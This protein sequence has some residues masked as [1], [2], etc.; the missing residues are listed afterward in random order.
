LRSAGDPNNPRQSIGISLVLVGVTLAIYAQSFSFG[1]VGF[2]D[3]EYLGGS[4][5]LQNELSIEGLK[6]A[7]T[8]PAMS[9]YT[10]LTL[11][12]HMFDRTLFGDNAGGYHL[13]NAVLHALN[14]VLLFFTL[15]SMTGARWRSATVAL[16][17]AVHPLN[18]ESVAWISERKNVLSTL[19]WI[20]TLWAYARYARRPGVAR[21][22]GVALLLALGLLAKPMLVTLPLALLLLDYWPLGRVRWR[23]STA[24]RQ[25]SPFAARSIGFL[26]AEKL[27]LLAISAAASVATYRA[28][29]RG[30]VATESLTLLERLANAAVA[31]AR[32]LGKLVWPSDLAMHYPHPYLP[33]MGGIPLEAWQ[34]AGSLLLLLALTVASIAALR[35]RYLAVGWL[36]FLG[37]L[38][39]TIG[40]VQVGHQALADRYAYVPAIGL[41]LALSWAGAE[42]IARLRAWRPALAHSLLAVAAAGIAALALT[43]WH[44]VGYWRDSIS[45]FERTLALIPKNPKVSF[46]LANEYRARGNVKEAIRH[47]RIA[48]ETDP[49]ALR[50]LVNLGGA[51][52]SAGEH[53]AAIET[54]KAVLNL[55]PLHAHAY[56]NLGVALQMKGESASALASFRRAIELDSRQADAHS[57][58]AKALSLQGKHEEAIAHYREALESP[59]L[60]DPAGTSLALGN[61]LFNLGR[62]EAAESAYHDAIERDPGNQHAQSNLAVTLAQR[63]KLDEAIAHFRLA[64]AISPDF[65]AAHNG[66]GECLRAQG[67][68]EAAIEAYENALRADP[69]FAPAASN[70][71]KARKMQNPPGAARSR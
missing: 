49:N 29:S 36:W 13:T 70:L 11:A 9:N 39:P 51:L 28:Q 50:T 37:T 44:Q 24:E 61:A 63:G 33:E 25:A 38:V 22:L 64:I 54:C 58:L 46:N 69:G 66:L 43:S 48:L 47:Y 14:S 32:Y 20:L 35:R 56:N 4:I 26:I 19:F 2:D 42:G 27:P 18:V 15:L 55:H 23:G 71:E 40:V 7:L 68:V 45:L 6:W 34:I 67:K 53:D 8:T 31:Y 41:F 21:Y 1:S 62:I 3:P 30:F 12:S 59:A 65:A 16:L 57:N 17:F 52:N 60:A 5:H 10:P